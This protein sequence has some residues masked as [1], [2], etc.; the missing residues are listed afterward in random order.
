V[1]SH[2]VYL[3]YD[4]LNLVILFTHKDFIDK[5]FSMLT[6]YVNNSFLLDV[7]LAYIFCLVNI[8]DI[9]NFLVLTF[10]GYYIN[11][12]CY[13]IVHFIILYDIYVAAIFCVIF[14][15]VLLNK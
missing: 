7:I 6:N 11:A 9:F 14:F 5:R 3:Y 1:P 10:Y 2:K 8:Y 12:I 4:T 13:I 15:L